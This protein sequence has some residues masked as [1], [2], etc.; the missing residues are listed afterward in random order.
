MS[1]NVHHIGI[2]VENL[3][4]ARLYYKTTWNAEIEPTERLEERGLELCFVRCDNTLVEL[5]A[6]IREDSTISKFLAQ[7]GPGLHHICYEVPDIRAEMQRLNALGFD[8]IDREP[9]PGA[10]GTI[11]AFL[12]PKSGLGTLIELLERVSA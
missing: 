3:E 8:L 10:S 6:P 4:A 2:V 12:H 9:R 11:I 5:L 7:R 1:L